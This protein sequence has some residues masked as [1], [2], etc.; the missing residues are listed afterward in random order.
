MLKV[1]GLRVP[2]QKQSVK[3]LPA[4]TRSISS[5]VYGKT[6]GVA[7]R[8][9]AIAATSCGFCP[10]ADVGPDATGVGAGTV[11]QAEVKVT[12]ATTPAR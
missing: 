7:C 12:S 10:A 8:N 4:C 6:V 3:P 5:T 9:V 11:V 1:C 2:T